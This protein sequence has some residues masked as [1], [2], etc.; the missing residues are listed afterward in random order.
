MPRDLVHYG[1]V[2][3]REMH[4]LYGFYF[5]MASSNGLL[6]RGDG[7]IRPFVLTRAFFAGSQRYGAMWTGDNTADWDHL[8]ASVPMVLT[9]GLTG[10]AFSGGSNI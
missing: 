4:N 8:K 7:K 1:G 5:Q 10:F 3:H 2:E 9:I 6:K